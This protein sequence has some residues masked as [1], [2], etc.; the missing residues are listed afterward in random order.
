M[1][2]KTELKKGLVTVGID[3]DAVPGAEILADDK[4]AGTLHTR[5]GDRAIAFLRFDRAEGQMRA[6]DARIIWPV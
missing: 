5:A 3:G 1:K 6:E 4:P 2:H